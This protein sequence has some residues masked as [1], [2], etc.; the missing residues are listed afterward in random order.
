MHRIRYLYKGR[1]DYS[2]HDQIA[3]LII[4]DNAR[5]VLDI[6]CN[7]GFIG[8]ALRSN[9]WSGFITGVDKNKDFIMVT[10]KGT[11]NKFLNVD[12]ENGF[13]QIRKQFDAIVFADVL[14]HLNNPQE[15]LIRSKK[16]INK[17]GRIY[18]SLPNVANLFIR[19]HL[20]L[21]N[22]TYLDY[23]ILDKDH[24]HFFTYKSAQKLIKKAGLEIIS[25]FYTPVPVPFLSKKIILKKPFMFLYYLARFLS[26]V[27]K[28]IFAYQFIFVCRKK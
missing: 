20:L 14:E 12:I 11:Y 2:S 26:L 19:L 23:G 5:K 1:L 9:K 24:R 8:Q 6:G 22:F 21:G 13:S 3:H 16:N 7:R 27:R 17:N 4:K 15:A 25:S 18:I 10:R 28:E